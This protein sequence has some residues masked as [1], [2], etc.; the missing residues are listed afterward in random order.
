MPA[1]G[2]ALGL[3]FQIGKVGSA[4]APVPDVF[5]VD[6]YW[7]GEDGTIGQVVT[8]PNLTAATLEK[9]PIGAWTLSTEAASRMLI[10]ASANDLPLA[11]RVGATDVAKTA[12]SRGVATPQT[13]DSNYAQY[14]F[15]ASSRCPSRLSISG[16]FRISDGIAV[17]RDLV[18]LTKAGGGYVVINTNTGNVRIHADDGGSGFGPSIAFTPGQWYFFSILALRSGTSRLRVYDTSL[19]LV[20]ESTISSVNNTGFISARIGRCDATGDFSAPNNVGTME[21]ADVMIDHTNGI[22]P[23]GIEY[24]AADHPAVPVFDDSDSF[25]RANGAL[26]SGWTEQKA[27]ITIASN[28]AVASSFD[29][30]LPFAYRNGTFNQRQ[31]SEVVIDTVSNAEMVGVSVRCDGIDAAA[32]CVQ[33]VAR[34]GVQRYIQ[35][36]TD[37]TATNMFQVTFTAWA[38]GDTVRL[39]ADGNFIGLYRKPSGGSFS[40]IG[41]AWLNGTHAAGNPGIVL[42]RAAS[43]ATDG[44]ALSWAGGNLQY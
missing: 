20:G 28:K 25:D 39:V 10:G 24:N 30:L 8:V 31:Y 15:G 19:T 3:P 14:A 23:L 34:A 38:I 27:G 29:A 11:L 12:G 26:G 36:V 9:Y 22:Y 43:W 18:I 2:L 13:Y 32:D 41:S 6:A 17:N 1:L 7:S 35:S 37:A 16:W 33:Y 21:V 42:G 44:K 40:L 4:P 5:P